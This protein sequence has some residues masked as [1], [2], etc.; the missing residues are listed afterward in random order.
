MRVKPSAWTGDYLGTMNPGQPRRASVLLAIDQRSLLLPALEAAVAL[1]AGCNLA[2]LV[3]FVDDASSRRG[4]A[5]GAGVTGG[6]HEAGFLG[7][8]EHL[9]HVVDRKAQRFGV[10]WALDLAFG[11]LGS[12]ALE[13]LQP[14]DLLVSQEGPL[15]RFAIGDREPFPALEGRPVLVHFGASMAAWR[16]LEAGRSMAQVIDTEL[17]V[18]LAHGAEAD[19]RRQ[20]V[21]RWLGDNGTA[22]R[23]VS[24]ASEAHAALAGAAR[25]E[26]AGALVWSGLAEGQGLGALRELTGRLGCPL[27]SLWRQVPLH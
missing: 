17:V 16:A 21:A 2:L 10:S 3:L 13:R 12:A 6:S 4:S 26:R 25:D 27:V 23:C 24:L 14:A 8:V 19:L 15:S 18:L 7:Q 11:E 9:R 20:R 1:C 5:P 22:A